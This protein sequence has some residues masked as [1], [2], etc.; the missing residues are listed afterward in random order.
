M[1]FPSGWK[2]LELEI[3]AS[4]LPPCQGPVLEGGDWLGVVTTPCWM[5]I[6]ESPN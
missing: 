3:K 4:S 6:T 5:D 2:L 1:R